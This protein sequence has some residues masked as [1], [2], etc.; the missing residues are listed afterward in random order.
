MTGTLAVQIVQEGLFQ[1]LK[2]G[3]AMS[4]HPSWQ[5]AAW[6][7][8]GNP[9]AY[10]RRRID[11][12]QALKAV[13]ANPPA[14]SASA[15][16]TGAFAQPEPALD[17][18]AILTAGLSHAPYLAGL[19]V[20][21]AR[22][23][24]GALTSAPDTA[25]IDLI[26]RIRSEAGQAATEKALMRV[27]RVGKRRAALLI[28]LA[29]LSGLWSL[30]RV[31]LALSEL[32]DLTL[33]LALNHRLAA[34][35]ASGR[36]NPALFGPGEVGCGIAVLGMGKLGAFELNYSSDIDI[37]IIYDSKAVPVTEKAEPTRTAIGLAQDLVRLLEERTADGYVFRVD[38]RL[39]PDPGAT[40]IAVSLAAA[41]S[42]YANLAQAWE[43][44]AMIK[45][46]VVAGDGAVG[47]RFLS[48]IKPFVWRR[49]VDFAAVEDLHAIRQR[50]SGHHGHNH[51][52][53]E[54]HNVKLGAGG[55]REVEFLTQTL[56]LVFGGREPALRGRQTEAT[57]GALVARRRLE[58]AERD[59]LIGAYRFLRTVEH[60]LQM[61]DDRQTQT[62]PQ[63]P[64]ALNAI[65]RFCGFAEGKAF[66]AQLLD[67]LST[68]DRLYAHII[69]PT[70]SDGPESQ[71][72]AILGPDITPETEQQLLDF[73]FERPELVVETV[74]GWRSGRYRCT[75]SDRSRRLIGTLV[76]AIL[77]ALSRTPHPTRA[78]I[79]FDRFLSR[80][81][82]GVQLFSMMQAT[83]GL[84]ALLAEM[85]GTS[86]R[87]ANH[88]ADNPSQ[89]DSVLS[90]DFF[91]RLPA[92]GRLEGELATL[93]STALDYEDRLNIVR[94]WT[95]DYRFRA[96]VHLLRG[97]SPTPNIAATLT[98]VAEIGLA[99]LLPAVMEAFA[100]RHGTVPGGRFAVI[101]MGKLGSR[102]MSIRSD[103]DL[104]M[105]YDAPE[106]VTGSDGD[107]PLSP[108]AYFTRLIQ[109]F[110]SAITAPTREGPLYEV[111]MRLRPSGNAG[112]LATSLK[113]FI[114]Y[115]TDHAWTWERMAMT[116]ARPIA[117]TPSL[118]ADLQSVIGGLLVRRVDRGD[119][120]RDAATMRLR[121][122]KTYPGTDLWSVKHIPGGL[123]DAEFV[124][125]AYQLI[126]GPEDPTLFSPS[127][128]EALVRLR[129]AGHL[130][131]AATQALID[132]HRACQA[133]QAY[134]RL[135]V[136][137]RF[138]P[139]AA[140]PSL[141]EGLARTLLSPLPSDQSD[142]LEAAHD[143]L[144]A[145]T[146]AAAAVFQDL[147]GR[148]ATPEVP[149][150]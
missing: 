108:T 7:P 121:I 32:A 67:H 148:Y 27:L 96:G 104:I 119:V 116:R 20:R 63:D 149:A 139:A 29:D 56:Q 4:L 92:S 114:H 57:L 115:Q 99:Q 98:D 135:T 122:A 47:H 37:I 133:V 31:T 90:T 123:V 147:V 30:G 131:P 73:G 86:D 10:A 6:P 17:L 101:A 58:P 95:N 51:I 89:L 25:W 150:P 124:A 143:R 93:L 35:T 145:V 62:L 113:A 44:A 110:L 100:E 70:R 26:D 15:A 77:V 118:M 102:E 94:Q 109:R 69:R 45:A 68:V 126:Y 43:R 49:T 112:P 59:A 24:P 83:P 106:G 80:L 65:G 91:E 81:P 74:R 39:R 19:M 76:G 1:T 120:L 75:R 18:E 136:D 8:I 36:L 128:V 82:A 117:G 72:V 88:L 146:T 52:A 5:N 54:G 53:L 55:I 13:A 22:W 103:L 140:S 64:A 78:F 2:L 23:W 12:V 138:D 33:R 85:L 50:I 61:V 60:R 41:Q 97:L 66:R 130:D 21:E 137:G 134:L 111:D 3:V 48:F 127:T 71:A 105:V 142:L 42:Y 125:Q 11:V 84:I 87:L 129:R 79:Q 28:A 141:R 16:L 34:L 38:L 132:A 14:D 40:P 144:R 46:R 9:S 107:K